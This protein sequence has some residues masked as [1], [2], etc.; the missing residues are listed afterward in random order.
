VVWPLRVKVLAAAVVL[1]ASALA[2]W[3]LAQSFGPSAPVTVVVGD[4]Q[5]PAPRDRVDAARLGRASTTLPQAPKEL[6]RRELAGGVELSPVV[7]SKGGVIVALSSP[8]V[9]RLNGVGQQ[10]WRARLGGD[11][12]AAAPVL[13]S[14]GSA[15]VLTVDGVLHSISSDGALTSS[16]A[17]GIDVGDDSSRGAS[18]LAR[19]DGS[20]VVA[21]TGSIVIV[22]PRGAVLARTSLEGRPAGGLLPWRGGVLVT[23]DE[24]HVFSW[25]PP[26]LPKK[27]GE[28]G[29]LAP[30][31]AS[32]VSDR[33]VVSVVGH[34]RL[35][36]LDLLRGTTTLLLRSTN[37]G[38]PLEAAVALT[39]DGQ[40]LATS[41]MGELLGVDARGAFVRRQ[42]L[43]KLSTLFSGDGGVPALFRPAQIQAS[44][45][46]VVDP[47]GRVA[48]A[49]SSGKVGVIAAD[50][51]VAVASARHCA[52][53]I[54][55][56]PAGTGRFVVVCRSGSVAMFGDG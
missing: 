49:R 1:G 10:T 29:A 11:A 56:L 17:L 47:D 19:D 51:T 38:S 52:R 3:S 25:K 48:F 36:A 5:G 20:V 7:D 18:P 53:P 9:V 28:L 54:A 14:D 43:E 2:S 55:L 8:D 41:V 21:G 15:K 33:T 50:G 12:A 26:G 40:L 16:I 31:G 13:A 24:G 44:P 22:G 4:P 35:V 23:T 42:A 6:W 37:P 46:L 34:D 27:R 30:A 39:P 45:P 32:L